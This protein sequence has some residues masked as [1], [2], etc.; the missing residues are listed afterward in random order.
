MIIRQ[1]VLGVV[2]VTV[3]VAGPHAWAGDETDEIGE[4]ILRAAEGQI[5]R[6]QPPRAATMA[7]DVFDIV[8]DDA[9]KW[10]ALIMV[11]RYNPPRDV[12]T[13]AEAVA[14]LQEWLDRED[15]GDPELRWRTYEVMGRLSDWPERNEFYAQALRIVASNPEDYP[16]ETVRLLKGLVYSPTGGS[17]GCDGPPRMI[18]AWVLAEIADAP[19]VG[20]DRV[21]WWNMAALA[22]PIFVTGS[23][24]DPN[25]PERPSLAEAL[26]EKVRTGPGDLT[27]RELDVVIRRN[28]GR[29]VEILGQVANHPSATAA[30]REW[31]QTKLAKTEEPSL[32]IKM[33]G[34]VPADEPVV[35][36]LKTKNLGEVMVEVFPLRIE[37]EDSGDKPLATPGWLREKYIPDTDPVVQRRV[38]IDIEET[39]IGLE[40]EPLPV[41]VWRVRFTG[42]GI[43]RIR[44]FTVTDAN[45]M[46][47]RQGD[48]TG[49]ALVDA[50]TGLPL[51]GVPVRLGDLSGHGP[52]WLA[53]L[54]TDADGLAI[55]DDIDLCPKRHPSH[56]PALA[57]QRGEG[58]LAW[59]SGCPSA[60]PS[61]GRGSRICDGSLFSLQLAVDSDTLERGKPFRWHAL[62]TAEENSVCRPETVRWK[63]SGQRSRD[64]VAQG[65]LPVGHD[66]RLTDRVVPRAAWPDDNYVITFEADAP[67][68]YEHERRLY[69]PGRMWRLGRLADRPEPDFEVKFA[70]SG[71]TAGP[72]DQLR[73]MVFRPAGMV[74]PDRVVIE[75]RVQPISNIGVSPQRILDHRRHQSKR[76]ELLN[77]TIVIEPG[78]AE[79]IELPWPDH[80]A[81]ILSASARFEEARF[82]TG[83]PTSVL[84]RDEPPHRPVFMLAQERSRC[85]MADEPVF[86]TARDLDGSPLRGAPLEIEVT[87]PHR[88]RDEVPVRAIA[89]RTDGTGIDP[90]WDPI[91]G[92]SRLEL[93]DVETDH[94]VTHYIRYEKPATGPFEHVQIAIE[95]VEV[96]GFDEAEVVI[97]SPGDGRFAVLAIGLEEPMILFLDRPE[98]RLP[99]PET[100]TTADSL[101]AM[102]A[103]IGRHRVG[104]V[105]DE[106]FIRRPLTNP[107]Y[108]RWIDARVDDDGT[109]VTIDPPLRRAS[110]A[111]LGGPVLWPPLPAEYEKTRGQNSL[112]PGSSWFKGGR[113]MNVRMPAPPNPNRFQKTAAPTAAE[114]ATVRAMTA[115]ERPQSP[116]R[117][118]LPV[119][120]LPLEPTRLLCLKNGI[121][122]GSDASPVCS[123]LDEAPSAIAVASRDKPVLFRVIQP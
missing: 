32:E 56:E 8:D 22:R 13:R 81:A 19:L 87:P 82:A 61:V 1:I 52:L 48:D 28:W 76:R 26:A 103:T 58:W 101:Y 108:G 23:D 24:R 37:K 111:V 3:A 73:L 49:V 94:S 5:A 109:T 69:I 91:L 95:P 92:G 63:I 12:M 2:A 80:S 89:V 7:A 117:L 106:V 115:Y 83:A 100:R 4:R 17:Y 18:P 21:E 25:H 31:A 93:R 84:I 78:G 90:I 72:D 112:Y 43:V 16:S 96:D 123:D 40:L 75:I 64:T 54:I 51:A 62:I 88:L 53:E 116:R 74:G 27:P 11:R 50:D 120:H 66:G 86:V 46:V 107:G 29:R 71:P 119:Y 47:W 36:V 113:V 38:P 33:S 59:Y 85:E 14:D 34:T 99:V 9:L 35:I 45:W 30:Q 70:P 102:L 79:V 98:I 55:F 67:I 60:R 122:V 41:G 77:R 114:R 20:E 57:I 44:G 10:R 97:R 121:R 39:E 68:G 118:I 104:E 65:E 105:S 110:V 42:E 6:G 15:I